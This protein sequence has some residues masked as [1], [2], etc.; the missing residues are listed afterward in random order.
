MNKYLFWASVF[1]L[2]AC[3]AQNEDLEQWMHETSQQA[4]TIISKP[5]EAKLNLQPTYTPP[6]QPSMNMFDPA[7]LKAGLQGANA[8]NPNKPKEI[9]ENYPLNELRYVG[10]ISSASK[11][12][13]AFVEV[14]GHVYT[15][16]VG[17]YLGQNY[18]RITAITPDD[19]VISEL[20]EDANGS[21]SDH[22]N[23]LPMHAVGNIE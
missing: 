20:L 17:N 1:V 9:L 14:N 6:P 3:S 16:T 22:T 19:I 23:S 11:T 4:K 5:K 15:V 18:G 8:P 10:L 7:K 2:S 12:P 21:W 13:S